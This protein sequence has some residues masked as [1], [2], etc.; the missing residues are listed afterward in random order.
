MVKIQ[1][2]N[3][4][5]AVGTAS[6]HIGIDGDGN[7]AVGFIDQLTF[8]QSFPLLRG[9][10]KIILK[11]FIFLIEPLYGV[12]QSEASIDSFTHIDFIGQKI[13]N[14]G[15]Y[16][17]GNRAFAFGFWIIDINTGMFIFYNGLVFKGQWSML[18]LA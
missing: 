7:N 2:S 18:F 12:F 8:Y 9:I 3:M 4:A 10:G 15:V 13:L 5:I 6:V 14:A 1:K 11:R 17:F 16:L